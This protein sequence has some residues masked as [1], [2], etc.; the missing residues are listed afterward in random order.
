VPP[1]MLEV[2]HRL[3]ASRQVTSTLSVPTLV[4]FGLPAG[5]E[6]RL[7]SSL[8]SVDSDSG[9]RP[10]DLTVG[11]KAEIAGGRHAALGLLGEMRFDFDDQTDARRETRLGLLGDLTFLHRLTLRS[12]AS[13][14]YLSGVTRSR[15]AFSYAGELSSLLTERWLLFVGSSGLVADQTA[16]RIEGGTTVA[17]TPSLLVGIAGS[18]GVT[19]AA[20]KFSAALILRWRL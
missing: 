5:L 10:P 12:N 18:G 6:A 15:Y 3:Q 4:R 7:A 1:F 9:T 2:G 19:A 11:A 8:L 17:V 20:E 13:L 14:E 16:V